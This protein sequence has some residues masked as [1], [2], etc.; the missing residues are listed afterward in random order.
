MISIAGVTAFAAI[1]FSIALLS[2]E[3]LNAR[4]PSDGVGAAGSRSSVEAGE[5]PD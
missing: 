2:P 1:L 5:M 4:A 3:D